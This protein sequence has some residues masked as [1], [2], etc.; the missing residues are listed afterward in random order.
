MGARLANLRD[1]RGLRMTPRQVLLMLPD[2]RPH[3]ARAIWSRQRLAV[4]DYCAFLWS[5][6]EEQ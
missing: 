1:L 6:D 2:Y 3:V 4:R 5:E